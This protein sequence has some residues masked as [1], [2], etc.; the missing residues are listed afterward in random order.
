M[1]PGLTSQHDEMPP[2]L[3][4]SMGCVQSFDVLAQTWTSA[5]PVNPHPVS[6]NS[7]VWSVTQSSKLTPSGLKACGRVLVPRSTTWEVPK[8]RKRSGAC[9]SLTLIVGDVT[10]AEHGVNVPVV[11]DVVGVV[12]EVEFTCAR[13]TR[14]GMPSART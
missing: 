14:D 4:R 3:P 6:L 1:L 5:V 13:A 7:S 8:L 10:V 2:W 11:V 12:D 9:W